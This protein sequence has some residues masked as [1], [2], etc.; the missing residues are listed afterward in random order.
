MKIR[1]MGYHLAFEPT[2]LILHE[3]RENLRDFANTFYR[4]GKGNVYVMG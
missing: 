1:R 3:Y 4:Y 2:A